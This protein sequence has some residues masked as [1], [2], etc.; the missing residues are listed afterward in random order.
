MSAKAATM[1]AKDATMSAKDATMSANDATMSAKDATKSAKD[2]TMCAK[3]ATMS[4]KDATQGPIFFP[5]II[6]ISLTP[7]LEE[8]ERCLAKTTFR[9]WRLKRRGFSF[10]VE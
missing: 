10:F 1:S 6:V 4:A 7:C 2:A 3:G 9:A 8:K 5:R